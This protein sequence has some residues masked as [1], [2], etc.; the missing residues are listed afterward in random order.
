MRLFQF[1]HS[2]VLLSHPFT[3]KILLRMYFYI[4]SFFFS[5]C[6][7]QSDSESSLIQSKRRLYRRKY[8]NYRTRNNIEQLESSDE[9]RDNCFDLIEQVSSL[10]GSVF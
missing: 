2:A 6:I 9:E 1:L 3:L 10:P 7:N 4:T 8:A 5:S